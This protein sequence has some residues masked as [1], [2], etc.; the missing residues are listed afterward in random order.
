MSEE[1][2]YNQAYSST[3]NLFG[4][5]PDMVLVNHIHLLDKSK[6]VLDIGSGQGRHALY[7]ARH[8]FEAV[9]LDPSGEATHQLQTTAD[10]EQLPILCIEGMIESFEAESGRFGTVLVFGLIQIFTWEQTRD[11]IA[12]INELIAPGG[13]VIFTGWTVEDSSLESV[14]KRGEQIGANSYRLPDGNVRTYLELG[15]VLELFAGWEIVYHWEG[16][17]EWHRHGDSEPERHARVE[18][19][20]K[21]SSM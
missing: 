20:F 7:L 5:E 14:R 11:L 21:K 3:P 19:V 13:H 15:Q 9:A 4:A 17:G 18:A 8:G 1:K 6:P 12:R 2:A 10:H 16:L